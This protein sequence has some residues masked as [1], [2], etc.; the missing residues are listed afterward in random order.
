VAHRDPLYSRKL[1]Q[2]KT[3]FPDLAPL[4]FWY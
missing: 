1:G 4:I 3:V 2:M